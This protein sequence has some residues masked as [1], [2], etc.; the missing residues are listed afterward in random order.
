MSATKMPAT[1]APLDEGLELT[2]P[3][4]VNPPGA[5]WE[6]IASG[7]GLFTRAPLMWIG[8]IVI[9]FIIAIVISIIPLIGSLIFQ[10][11]QGVFIGGFMVACRALEKG[12][13]FEL[14][15]LFAGFTRR[16]VPLLVVDLLFLAGSIVILLIC[17][18]PV[19]F[20][21]L[22]AVM[23][24]DSDAALGA[25]MASAGLLMLSGLVALGLLVPLMAA[26]WFAPT[27]VMLHDMKPLAAMKASFFACFRNFVPFLVYGLVMFVGMILAVL[28]MG[29]G[30]IV[31]IPVAIASTYVAYRMIFTD[32][33]FQAPGRSAA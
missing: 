27:L 21:I 7:W 1:D 10:L 13:D 6:W 29:L 28:P 20:S 15:H 25:V 12:G 26:Y 2:L 30:L 14:E 5:G 11:L 19:G 18:V 17:A 33:V 24:G 31:W 23:A 32:E 16:L 22:S 4:R 3:G 8:S 9:V